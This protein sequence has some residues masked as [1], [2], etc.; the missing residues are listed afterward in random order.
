MFYLMFDVIVIFCFFFLMIRRPPRSTRTDTLFPYTTLFRSNGRAHRP[1]ASERTR[2]GRQPSHRAADPVAHRR[3]FATGK[4]CAAM[5]SRNAQDART[6]SEP[7]A[8]RALPRKRH[9]KPSR[10]ARGVAGY[11]RA[12]DAGAGAHAGDHPAK[13]ATPE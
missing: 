7:W 5:A 12:A 2:R 8:R 6:L 13:P 1:C 11:R 4:P 3:G 9:H 10:A